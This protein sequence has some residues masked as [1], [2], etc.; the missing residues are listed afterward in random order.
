MYLVNERD[1]KAELNNYDDIIIY[2]AGLVGK[3]LLKY[4]SKNYNEKNIYIAVSELKGNQGYIMGQCV[5]S[6]IDLIDM[7]NKACVIVATMENKQDDIIDILNDY[8][9]EH[10]VKIGNQLYSSLRGSDPDFSIDTDNELFKIRNQLIKLNLE[11]SQLKNFLPIGY[12]YYAKFDRKHQ[13][14]FKDYFDDE[15]LL[16]EKYLKL[17]RNLDADSIQTVNLIL[18]RM[19]LILTSSDEFYD[20]F[21]YEEKN[22]IRNKADLFSSQ[23]LKI[24][25]DLYCYKNYKLQCNCF[26]EEVFYYQ[27]GLNKL[28][29]IDLIKERDIID[30]GAYVGD[31]A[32][33]LSPLSKGKVYAFEAFKG[34]Y[35]QLLNTIKLNEV[36]NVIPIQIAL[37]AEN[38]LTSMN[39][40]N[41]ETSCNSL[42]KRDGVI[43]AGG[44]VVQEKTLDSFVFE[45]NL[46]VGLIKVD[47]EGAEQ[48]FL[49]GA[50]ETIKRY[51]PILIISIYHS[52]AD[53]FDIKPLLEMLGVG[54]TFKIYRPVIERSIISE[55]LL[56]AEVKN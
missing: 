52:A 11:F 16:K 44:E 29:T 47:I 45:N 7:A 48:D 39:I 33:V 28:E 26:S 8:C 55:T 50:L 25:D 53:F 54:Y 22:D 30:V 3:T 42:V 20:I 5:Y 36:K 56:L 46:N 49:K 23:I 19:Q 15:E 40:M 27:L 38:R 51:K 1:L 13:Q 6:I 17:V 14:A 2:G 24:S 34:S 32:L 43:Y 12:K 18:K 9:F 4:L 41:D 35:G 31:S 10:I 21:T 37:G